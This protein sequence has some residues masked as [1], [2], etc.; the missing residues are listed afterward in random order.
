[1]DPCTPDRC[2]LGGPGLKTFIWVALVGAREQRT[3]S[4]LSFLKSQLSAC[5]EWAVR[6]TLCSVRGAVLR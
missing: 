3:C 5:M 2:Y 6:S 4:L 1:M